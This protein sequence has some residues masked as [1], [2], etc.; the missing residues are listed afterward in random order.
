[1]RPNLPCFF[2]AA[3]IT[4]LIGCNN[5]DQQRLSQKA[6]EAKQK[7][8]LGAERLRDD[9]H[10]LGQRAKQEAHSLRQNVDEA[11]S[12]TGPAHAGGATGQAEEKLRRGGQDL[13]VAGEQAG[14]KLDR[15]AI[16]AKVKAKLATDVGLS[17]VAGI[18]VDASGQVVT[19]RGS[20]ASEDQKRQAEQAALQVTGVNRVVNEIQVKP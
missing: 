16:V 12:S 13:R 4:V 5:T 9:A 10:K 17:T 15:A 11:L 1:M 3:L 6:E 20:V 19:L 2:C 8:R 14:R 7:A 18:D